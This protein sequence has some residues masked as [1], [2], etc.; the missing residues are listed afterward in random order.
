M[1]AQANTWL[2]SAQ[3]MGLG[4]ITFDDLRRS[5]RRSRGVGQTTIAPPA[6]GIAPGSP[7]YD[8]SHDNGEYHCASL[9]SVLLSAL[10]FNSP[11]GG[12]TTNC[13]AAEQAC[14]AGGSTPSGGILTAAQQAVLAST[15]ATDACTP[16]VGIS[17]NNLLLI[18]LAV[19]A[20]V[21]VLAVAK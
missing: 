9:T 15:T 6:G 10:P 8:P 14:F 18:G 11:T 13:S 17:C 20:G 2:P 3:Q 1:Y 4:Q 12:M 19:L 7:C 16:V 21:V 5:A